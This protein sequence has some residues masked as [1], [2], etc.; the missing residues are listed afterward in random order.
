MLSFLLSILRLYHHIP[1]RWHG[2]LAVT[3]VSLRGGFFPSQ[4]HSAQPTV[5]YTQCSPALLWTS[6]LTEPVINACPGVP[7]SG[8]RRSSSVSRFTSVTVHPGSWLFAQAPPAA[9]EL[10]SHE[11]ILPTF[12]PARSPTS[13]MPAPECPLSPLGSPTLGPL[14]AT[15]VLRG[16]S[17]FD[18]GEAVTFSFRLSS[19]ATSTSLSGA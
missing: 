7:G 8:R 16:F 15:R 3:F 10:H 17:T 6:P 2:W 12:H 14:L 13:V 9:P 19:K 11:D 18:F 4:P 1:G 5:A